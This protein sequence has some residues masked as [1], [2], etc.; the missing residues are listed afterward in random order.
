MPSMALAGSQSAGLD[1]N[2]D[3]AAVIETTTKAS[4]PTQRKSTPYDKNGSA[5]NAFKR[6]DL[7]NAT[8]DTEAKAKAEPPATVAEVGKALSSLNLVQSE[9][10]PSSG[11]A[12]LG[13]PPS[14]GDN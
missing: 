10:S 2:S 8:A 1:V 6:P 4:V 5:E 13:G 14:E 11:P 12:E 7:L 9:E 3:V